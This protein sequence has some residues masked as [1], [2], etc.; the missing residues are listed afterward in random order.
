MVL[1]WGLFNLVE[2]IIDHHLL[3]VHHVVE[4]LGDSIWDFAFLG[5]GRRLHRRRLDA[6]PLRARRCE[7]PR[8]GVS[9]KLEE[10]RCPTRSP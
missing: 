2:G 9:R 7:A 1:G 6:H 3:N 4:R 10:R 5:F 8:A